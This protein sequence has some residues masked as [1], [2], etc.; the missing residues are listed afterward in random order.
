MLIKA[1]K[2]LY[3]LFVLYCGWFQIVFFAIPHMLL[4]LG[5]GMMYFI[6]LHSLINRT[7]LLKFLTGE[8]Q[9]WL[10][11]AF[12][13]LLFGLFVAVNPDNLIGSVTTFFQ[14]LLLI[15]GI[16][17]I[18]NQDGN[19]DFF[20]NVFIIFVI[21]CAI[22][23]IFWGVDSINEKGRIVM[24]PTDNPNSLGFIMVYGI[25][26]ILYKQNLTK[27]FYSLLS[28]SFVLLLIYVCIMTGS[29]KSFISIILFIV[30]WFVYIAF[31]E[32]KVSRIS[33]K[34]KVMISMLLLIGAAYYILVPYFGN[35]VLTTRFN[36]FFEQDTRENMY[37]EAFEFFK[38]SPLVG[39]GLNNFRSLSMYKTYSH[40]TY[41]EALSCTGIIGSILYF[42]PYILLLLHYRRMLTSKLNATLIK[43]TRIMLG[44]FGLLLFLGV[45]MIHFYEI[46][47]T[48]IFGM[49]FAFNNVNKNLVSK[50]NI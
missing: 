40:S 20:I 34:L 12:T 25:C 44:L 49:L 47:S 13:S 21:I 6:V 27:L 48:I 38:Q 2:V 30:Y 7:S 15:Y 42:T 5:S 22:T 24:G 10:L 33:V 37:L 39:V 31:N 16:I 29:R 23:T 9:L 14:Y 41:A 36:T 32:I 43:Q 19:I 50:H 1:S 35:T 46:T 26:F 28:L 17:Y 8:L 11:F 45:G 4:I 18:S 3:I